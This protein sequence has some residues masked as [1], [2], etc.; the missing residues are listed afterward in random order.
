MLCSNCQ[1]HFIR[2]TKRLCPRVVNFTMG[3]CKNLSGIYKTGFHQK[4]SFL[5]ANVI[6]QNNMPVIS[7]CN[8]SIFDKSEFPQVN[9]MEGFESNQSTSDSL[10]STR[11]GLNEGLQWTIPN[12]SA[13][14]LL[15]GEIKLTGAPHVIVTTV[16]TS[17][18]ETRNLLLADIRTG[19][20]EY[21]LFYS[22]EE[23]L[24][25][26]HNV[27]VNPKPFFNFVELFRGDGFDNLIF[28]NIVMAVSSSCDSFKE[29]KDFLLGR[30][31][32]HVELI[33]NHSPRNEIKYSNDSSD[34]SDVES[35]F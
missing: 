14:I 28:L 8:K 34:E 12:L 26:L 19:V 13:Y 1:V 29:G 25:L 6:C 30:P 20:V 10:W 18:G 24:K 5:V 27:G 3:Q 32:D 35:I 15:T 11:N 4:I 22:V 16:K 2:E 17:F 33:H 21:W 31:R 23:T 7:D 9:V